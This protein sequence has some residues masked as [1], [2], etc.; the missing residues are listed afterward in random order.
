MHKGRFQNLQEK[1]SRRILMWD[2][3]SQGGKEILIKAIAQ[4]IPSYLMGVFKFPMSVCDDLS[5]MV[6]N[7]W[8][9]SSDGKRKTHW[10]SW[11]HLNK[12]KAQGGLGFRDFR[13]FNQPLLARQVW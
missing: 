1:L 11:D 6:R 8:W 9:G 10:K 2:T 4:A 5:R 12:P 13:V 3:P 7:Y